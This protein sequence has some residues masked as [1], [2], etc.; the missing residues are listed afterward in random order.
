MVNNKLPQLFLL[1]IMLAAIPVVPACSTIPS[2]PSNTADSTS[3][4][5]KAPAK[6]TQQKPKVDKQG[7]SSQKTK[8]PGQNAQGNKQGQSSQNPQ[9]VQLAP[10]TIAGVNL[11]LGQPTDNS[12]TANVLSDK[13]R[14]VY[15]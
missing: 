5:N 15:F 4:H 11:L 7:Q 3:S 2:I 12:I 9:Y 1:L 10:I 14:E 8:S 13:D 6:D